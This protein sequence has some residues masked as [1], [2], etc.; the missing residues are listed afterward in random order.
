M[1]KSID[2]L[3]PDRGNQI[4][5]WRKEQARRGGRMDQFQNVLGPGRKDGGG[6]LRLRD[7]V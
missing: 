7:L 5:V 1:V 6:N 3:A 2:L 4:Q